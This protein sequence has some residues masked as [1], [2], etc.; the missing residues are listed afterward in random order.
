MPS[1]ISCHPRGSLSA[2]VFVIL[3]TLNSLNSSNSFP[4]SF[5]VLTG[6]FFLFCVY[7]STLDSRS[8]VTQAQAEG[9]S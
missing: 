7:E 4:I 9:F 5:T 8:P 1:V 3:L 6:R 2:C